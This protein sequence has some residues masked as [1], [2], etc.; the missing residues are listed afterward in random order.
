MWISSQTKE[1]SAKNQG[2]AALG[3]VTTGGKESS[4]YLGTQRRGLP[5]AAPGGYCWR[6]EV[7]EQVLVLKAGADGESSWILAR[8]RQ[9]T[10]ELL[11]GEVALNGPDCALKLAKSGTVELRGQVSIN[12]TQLEDLIRSIAA[13]MLAQEE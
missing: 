3:V 11:P 7:G 6:P 5:V 10:D 4:V 13:Q 1:M 12:G 8:T 2:G 9:E